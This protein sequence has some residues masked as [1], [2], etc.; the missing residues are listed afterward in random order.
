MLRA[1]RVSHATISIPGRAGYWVY[2][3]VEQYPWYLSNNESETPYSGRK[4]ST[5]SSGPKCPRQSNTHLRGWSSP[6]LLFP[7]HRPHGIVK[8]S[9]PRNS[10]RQG[11]M[12]RNQ[13]AS[14][15]LKTQFEKV[16]KQTKPAAG[17]TRTRTRPPVLPGTP[18]GSEPP[19]ALKHAIDTSGW[20][21]DDIVRFLLFEACFYVRP[22]RAPSGGSRSIFYRFCTGWSFRRFLPRNSDSRREC[23][24]ESIPL[25]CTN[26]KN[27]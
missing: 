7:C 18:G 12:R 13:E 22:G 24:F 14:L 17:V 1:I 19:L 11:R 25:R 2:P 10:Q 16:A 23:P 3:L 26:K 21:Q 15:Y 27:I 6:S 4:P 20:K 5:H 9:P 8:D